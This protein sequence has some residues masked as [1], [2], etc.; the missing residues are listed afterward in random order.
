[1]ARRPS[2]SV[3]GFGYRGCPAGCAVSTCSWVAVTTPPDQGGKQGPAWALVLVC[4]RQAD[5]LHRYGRSMTVTLVVN[6]LDYEVPGDGQQTLLDALR[7]DLEITGPKL[8]CGEGT[9]G[10]PRSSMSRAA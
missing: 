1:M 5:V 6:G 7:D 4:A 10:Q 9:C 2:A 3:T 8:G